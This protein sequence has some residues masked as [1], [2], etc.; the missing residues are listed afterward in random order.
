MSRVFDQSTFNRKYCLLDF[1]AASLQKIL[2]LAANDHERTVLY[3]MRA[4]R[5]PGRTL[6]NIKFIYNREPGYKELSFLILR[7]INKTEDWLLTNKVTG[8]GPASYNRFMI[9]YE[10]DLKE[11]YKRDIAYTR[12][13]Y[14]FVK[15]MLAEGKCKDRA[16]LHIYAAH[17][18]F[19]QGLYNESRQ[20]LSQAKRLPRLPANIKTQLLI[21]DFLLTLEMDA[22]FSKTSEHKLMQLLLASASTTGLHNPDLMRDQ[23]ILYTGRKLIQRGK[24]QKD[25]YYWAK[26]AGPWESCP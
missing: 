18:A 13:L 21:N 1:G 15:L 22:S 8:F 10:P 6:H 24:G 25:C 2:P 20:Y 3:A 7:E 12:E 19:T 9:D 17:L 26:P 23:V 14:D 4:F 11:N 5:D 16:L